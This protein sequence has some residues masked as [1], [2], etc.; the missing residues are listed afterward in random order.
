M[1]GVN[2]T[3]FTVGTTRTSNFILESPTYSYTAIQSAIQG[4]NPS[5]ASPALAARCKH[6]GQLI[7]APTS[8]SAITSSMSALPNA[9]AASVGVPTLVNSIQQV[10]YAGNGATLSSYVTTGTP[11]VNIGN[12]F[13]NT[14]GAPVMGEIYAVDIV[15]SIPQVAASSTLRTLTYSTYY[16]LVANSAGAIINPST[17][18]SAYTTPPLWDLSGYAFK[19]GRDYINLWISTGGSYSVNLYN[20]FNIATQYSI[21]SG[22]TIPVPTVS[23]ANGYSNRVSDVPRYYYMGPGRVV[24]DYTAKFYALYNWGGRT[25]QDV[26]PSSIPSFTPAGIHAVRITV[27][28]NINSWS[29]AYSVIGVMGADACY[30]AAA[31]ATLMSFGNNM[32]FWN[33]V[34]QYIS[35]NPTA[36]VSGWVSSA[37]VAANHWFNTRLT[38]QTF[39]PFL[40]APSTLPSST[41]GL[42]SLANIYKIPTTISTLYSLIATNYFN[43]AE[44][45]KQLAYLYPT[46]NLQSIQT[47]TDDVPN[48]VKPTPLQLYNTAIGHVTAAAVAETQL[49]AQGWATPGDIAQQLII[50]F[51]QMISDPNSQT[52]FTLNVNGTP[53]QYNNMFDFMQ[54]F[55]FSSDGTPYTTFSGNFANMIIEYNSFKLVNPNQFSNTD[56]QNPVP[57][58]QSYFMFPLQG[59]TSLFTLNSPLKRMWGQQI[60]DFGQFTMIPRYRSVVGNS[61]ATP[62]SGVTTYTAQIRDKNTNLQFYNVAYYYDSNGNLILY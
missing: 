33:N 43:A 49:L 31:A 52:G 36:Q 22:F 58:L 61:H 41:M 50:P 6:V 3:L 23:F 28:P 62:P 20:A 60:W 15:T 45:F 29:L 19:S 51:M 8:A 32:T 30:D 12:M 18:P 16:V 56:P 39:S 24:S 2:A 7:S 48:S 46:I 17:T 9:G 59:I 34:Q 40:S 10:A 14:S 37:F 25:L 4:A 44:Q 1:N 13:A 54:N 26:S 42:S 35:S 21:T 55:P 11:Q 53:T 5:S 27:F 57:Y 47:Y 38:P